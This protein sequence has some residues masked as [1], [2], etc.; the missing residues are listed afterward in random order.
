LKKLRPEEA[1]VLI[2]LQN[3]LKA[4]KPQTGA[5][6]LKKKGKRARRASL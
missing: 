4:S 5:V 1:A 3:R 6:A 2:L